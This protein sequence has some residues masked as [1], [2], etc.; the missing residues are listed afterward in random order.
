MEIFVALSFSFASILQITEALRKFCRNK[1]FS[2]PG[3]NKAGRGGLVVQLPRA[4]QS[5]KQQNKDFKLKR[6]VVKN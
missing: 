6:L 1:F 4:A 2:V 5:Q 3:L